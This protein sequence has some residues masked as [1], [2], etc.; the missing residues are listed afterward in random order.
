MKKNILITGKPKIGKSTLLRKIASTIPHKVGFVTQEM[1]GD[2]GR[3]GFEIEAHTGSKITLA[4]IEGVTLHKVSKYFVHIEKLESILPE[5][6]NFKK[7]DTLYIDEIGEM[8]LFSSAFKELVLNYLNSENR[9]VA[10]FSSVFE[11]DFIHQ[12]KGRDDVKIF[13]L[14]E[15]N[16]E[17]VENLIKH[18]LTTPLQRSLKN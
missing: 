14:T 17:E 7:E 3:V 5:V 8:Q 11:D 1:R 12:I 9:C 13:E 2:I 6:S 10:T 16:R 18:H 4:H 15:G